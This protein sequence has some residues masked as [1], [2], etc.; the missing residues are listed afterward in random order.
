MTTSVACAVVG[1]HGHSL[2][3]LYLDPDATFGDAKVAAKEALPR[4]LAGV[5]ADEVMLFPA[6]NE[7]GEFLPV[8]SHIGRNFMGGKTQGLEGMLQR[9]LQLNSD[10]RVS[11]FLVGTESDLSVVHVLIVS[12]L[13]SL[14]CAVVGTRKGEVT[15]RADITKPLQSLYHAIAVKAKVPEDGLRVF[16][17]VGRD[18]EWISCGWDDTEDSWALSTGHTTD[19]IDY[20]LR[21]EAEIK[22][23][24]ALVSAPDNYGSNAHILVTVRGCTPKKSAIGVLGKRG[25]YWD[26]LYESLSESNRSGGVDI[27]VGPVRLDKVS[28]WD[29]WD[30]YDI[31]TSTHL[32]RRIINDAISVLQKELVEE[33]TRAMDYEVDSLVSMVLHNVLRIVE[34]RMEIQSRYPLK[35][36]MN[37]LDVEGY[38]DFMLFHGDRYVCVME[39]TDEVDDD[40][41]DEEGE[42]SDEEEKEREKT[43]KY[44][45]KP[46]KMKTGLAHLL[47]AMEM[48]NTYMSRNIAG[49]VTDYY[50]WWFVSL[51]YES[52][53]TMPEVS[54]DFDA[55]GPDETELARIVGKLAILVS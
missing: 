25:R 28:W 48:L 47:V 13:R 21:D 16:L 41:D 35:S 40:D 29:L 42:D 3:L 37:V 10:D 11:E 54:I 44:E 22:D 32:C 1:A 15:V 23:P 49:V 30:L 7:S 18:G 6:K 51:N 8:N 39:A 52:E 33:E 43:S 2:F 4:Y 45:I 38:A 31:T 17:P 27:D 55:L 5:S 20:M 19:N 50:R 36:F 34:S 46:S 26:K 12:A 9:E 53:T 24:F 14:R